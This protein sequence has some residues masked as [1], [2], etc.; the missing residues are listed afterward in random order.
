MPVFS[1]KPCARWMLLLSV[2]F[3]ARVWADTPTQEY[4]RN[5]QR[6]QQLQEQ[7]Q[8]KAEVRAPTPSAASPAESVPQ[9]NESVCFPIQRITLESE[10][11]S[12]FQG[13]L[14]TALQ[15][16][17]FH[18]GMCLGT[19]G[20]N[21][22]MT[23][24]QNIVID[25]GYTTTRILAAPQDL[26]SGVLKLTVI[27]GRIH[28]FRYDESDAANTH[29][30]RIE[31]WNNAFAA[32]PGDILNLR[33]LEQGLENLKRVPTADADMQI[34]PANA[35]NQSDVVIRW[36]QR[37]LPFR[38]SFNAD[39]SGGSATG[40]YQGSVTLSVDNPLGLSDLFYVSYNHSLAD[41]SRATDSTGHR[42]EGN[43]AGYALH[44]SV[45]FGNW[46]F[47]V[48]HNGYR[49]HQA[50]PGDSQVYDYNGMSYSTDID[51]GRV[52]YRDARRKTTLNGKVWTRQ[53]RSFIDDAEIAV[54][55]RRTSGWEI[56]VEHKEY[57]GS[58]TFGVALNYRRGTGWNHALA[59]PE[60]A[61][62]EGTSRM[63]LLSAD[64]SA[65][66]PFQIGAQSWR[67][68]GSVHGQYALTR[69]LPQDRIGI[70]GRYSVRGFDGEQTL[71]AD[72]GF[73][74][75]NELDWQ[76][77][78]NHQLYLG[79]DAGHVGGPD[80]DKLIGQT[81]VGAVVGVKGRFSGTGTLAYDLFAGTPLYR[82][83]GFRTATVTVG[84]NLN[85]SF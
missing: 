75:R 54:Q 46:L 20:I 5:Q 59:A 78:P 8:P 67:Y 68:N 65:D 10:E 4:Q 7:I 69:L 29:V 27:P 42:L 44:Y 76:M 32:K 55:L 38:L 49:Y 13:A 2:G 31:S 53:T 12:R 41:A 77:V 43:T 19:Q 66:V 58:S 57:R 16:T 50:V 35:P 14:T 74:W 15:Q 26:K 64:I 25:R 84:F 61:F 45:P 83:Q 85:Y 18:P 34:V 3:G 70:G 1:L 28:A 80:A 11:A 37:T 62:N 33:D 23:V 52:L 24:T 56:G 48:N 40:R 22:I 30:A 47:A 17:R 72:N 51:A 79:V 21:R 71:L 36:R 60:E 73:Y 6:Q 82:P 81:L 9:Q 39:D 63:K